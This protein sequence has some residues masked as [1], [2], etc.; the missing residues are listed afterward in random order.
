M[1]QIAVFSG[2]TYRLFETIPG[3]DEASAVNIM[4][5]KLT[6]R[7]AVLDGTFVWYG[8]INYLSSAKPEDAAIRLE[9]PELAGELLDLEAD[10]E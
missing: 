1:N 2:T 3:P 4:Q 7:Y 10:A 6:Q 8:D 9:N 5:P